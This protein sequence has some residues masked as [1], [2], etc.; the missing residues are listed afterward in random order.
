MAR[1]NLFT[2]EEARKLIKYWL[3]V[4]QQYEQEPDFEGGDVYYAGIVSGL[5]YALHILDRTGD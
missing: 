5:E 1:R 3:K 4:N 2:D